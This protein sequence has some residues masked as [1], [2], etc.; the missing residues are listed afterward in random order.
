MILK[1]SEIARQIEKGQ[2]PKAI[3]PLVITPLPDVKAIRE[4]GSASVDIHLGTWFRTLRRARIPCMK[5]SQSESKTGGGQLF[6][7]EHYVPFKESFYLHP[8]SFALGIT[9]EWVRLPKNLAAVVTGKSSWGRRGLIIA[10]ATGVHPGF[11]GC[12][13][14]EITN[15]GE[16]PVEIKLGYP[17]CQLFIHQVLGKEDDLADKS[18]FALRRKPI[19]GAAPTD[20]ISSLLCPEEGK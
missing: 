6:T 20:A 4:S 2:S 18:A 7:T 19:F 1:G 17:I 3:D 16:I 12:L 15:L 8:R 11:S 14:L 9:L 10:T 13:T 5:T